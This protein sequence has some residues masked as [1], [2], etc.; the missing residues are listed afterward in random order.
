MMFCGVPFG[1]CSVVAILLSKEKVNNLL[2][3][4]F[5]KPHA[6]TRWQNSTKKLKN[7]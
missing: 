7:R 6:P 2:I 4:Y 3:F 1:R 5:A